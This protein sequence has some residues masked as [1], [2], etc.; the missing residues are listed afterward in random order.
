VALS[1]SRAV[2][3]ATGKYGS[4]ILQRC[5]Y[6]FELLKQKM[7]DFSIPQEINL[8]KIDELVACNPEPVVIEISNI[9]DS[10]LGKEDGKTAKEALEFIRWTIPTLNERQTHE[11]LQHCNFELLKPVPV[12]RLKFYKLLFTGRPGE[13]DFK[14][15]LVDY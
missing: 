13:H 10:D 3:Y 14:Y 7:P 1:L 15:R 9:D 5:I 8:F 11:F 4:E 12:E 6:L 2:V